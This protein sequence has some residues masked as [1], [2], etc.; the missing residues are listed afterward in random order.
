MCDFQIMEKAIKIAW[1]NRIQDESQASW[2]IIPNQFLHKHGGLVFL[3]KCNFATNT[4]D[5]DDK[6]PFIKTCQIIDASSKSQRAA[7][8]NEILKTKQCGITGKFLQEKKPAFYQTWYNAGI[9]NTVSDILNQ[10][11]DFLKWHEFA[12][13]FNLNVP[14][15]R[16]YGLDNA[17]PTKMES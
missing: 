14:F 5:L 7:I 4:L 1:I 16:Y 9:T 17:I 13:K 11:Q 3:T 2:K 12:I 10:N 6:L 8:P 15:T